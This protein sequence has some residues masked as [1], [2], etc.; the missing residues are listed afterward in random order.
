MHKY[1]CVRIAERHDVVA[2][3]HPSGRSP[4]SKGR[5]RSIAN[6]VKKYGAPATLLQKLSGRLGWNRQASVQRA[7]QRVFAGVDA[8]YGGRVARVARDVE[9]INGPDAVHLLADLEPD[10]VICLG[11]PIYRAP[12]IKAGKLML[13]YHTGISPI[14]NGTGT[15]FWTFANKHVHLAGGTLMVMSEVVDGGDILA[16]Y[17][18][19]IEADD[20]P[21][22]LFMKAIEGG[23]RLYDRFLRHL[24]DGGRYVS[25]PQPR[26]FFDYRGYEW[27]VS[28]TLSVQRSIDQRLCRRFERG[29]EIIEYWRLPSAE[30][31]RQALKDNVARWVCDA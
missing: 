27:T 14:Y 9:D 28:Q 23:T 15:I 12:L 29:E 3:L 24:S 25:V 7:Q 1:L 10:V 31:A 4:A 20:D 18:C 11:G 30:A 26:S 19:P 6:D 17:L 2:V 22:T 16:H 8:A 5:L 13:N 21:G